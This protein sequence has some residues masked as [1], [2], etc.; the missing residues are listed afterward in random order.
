M[1]N[2]EEKAVDE[3]FKKNLI[4]ENQKQEIIDYRVLKIFSLHNEL[5]FL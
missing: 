4:S 3:L 1:I 5:R 2:F